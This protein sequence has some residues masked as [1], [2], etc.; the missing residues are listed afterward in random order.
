MI[1]KHVDNIGTRTV[2]MDNGINAAHL[3]I[4]GDLYVHGNKISA[5]DLLWLI[6][7]LIEKEIN[8]RSKSRY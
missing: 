5:D 2:P 6:E 3:H 1:T 4:N 7:P 8:R